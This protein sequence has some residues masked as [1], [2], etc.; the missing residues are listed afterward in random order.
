[1]CLINNVH[2]AAY[3]DAA[4]A[5]VGRK[6]ALGAKAIMEDAPKHLT[7]LWPAYDMAD[8]PFPAAAEMGSSMQ[9]KYHVE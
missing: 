9:V 5:E 6:A 2:D 3:M 1:M 7:R 8:V 4:N